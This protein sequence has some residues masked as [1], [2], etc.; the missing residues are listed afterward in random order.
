MRYW[1]RGE[2]IRKRRASIEVATGAM[3]G[4][5]V[6]TRVK[7]AR[8]ARA[9]LTRRNFHCNGS[10]YFADAE[11]FHRPCNARITCVVPR[12]LLSKFCVAEMNV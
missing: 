7:W 12:P 3:V 11:G 2:Y 4:V 8:N 6:S 5:L 9:E 1:L 10:V